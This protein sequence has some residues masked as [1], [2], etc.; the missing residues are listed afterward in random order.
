MSTNLV[1]LVEEPVTA[2]ADYERAALVRN[3]WVLIDPQLPKEMY[4]YMTEDPKDANIIRFLLNDSERDVA[5]L[6]VVQCF[7]SAEPGVYQV[8][9]NFLPDA[10]SPEL[11]A[12]ALGRAL[13]HI[14]GFGGTKVSV[15]SFSP[16]AEL[17]QEL[18]RHG[19][20]AGQK[21]P[22][23]GCMLQEFDLEPWSAQYPLP[24]DLR[25]V[26]AAQ[27]RDEFPNDWTRRLH[28]FE[29]I[30]MQDVPLPQPF[31]P[32]A[33]EV[34]EA[35]LLSPFTNLETVFYLADGEQLVCGTA[36]GQNKVDPTEAFT[37]LTTTLRSYRRRGLARS[38]KIHAM[39]Q[40][41]SRGVRRLITD[42]E[43][44]NPMLQLNL[45]LGFRVFMDA[46]N[47]SRSVE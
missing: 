25:L 47:F 43:E 5:Y 19:F 35:G 29:N 32:L 27:L 8:N 11:F 26:T 33:H 24:S 36:F 9:M 15:W 1:H 42:N 31:Q 38:L 34:F 17:I 37:F 22:V 41:K 28:D 14:R 16:K 20:E 3:A 4:T 21:N 18:T 12:E 2:L 23:S 7:W 39:Q 40:A 44:S 13:R 6:S 30:G 46:V 10:F 45:A